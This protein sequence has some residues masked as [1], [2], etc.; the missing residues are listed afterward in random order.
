MSHLRLEN[1]QRRSGFTLV[2]L[3][4]VISIIALL[5]AL[6]L[7]ALRQAR[8]AARKAQ[9]GTQLRSIGQLLGMYA[10]DNKG[11]SPDYSVVR[12]A[13]GG[14]ERLPIVNGNRN[15]T[16][17]ASK[18]AYLGY[19]PTGSWTGSTTPATYDANAMYK[20]LTCPDEPGMSNM[21]FQQFV[22][23]YRTNHNAMG[24]FPFG[25]ASTYYTNSCRFDD[26][27]KP[28]SFF[29]L[30]ESNMSPTTTNANIPQ[31]VNH[32]LD[33]LDVRNH[34]DAYRTTG[35]AANLYG[36][37]AHN[38]SGNELFADFHVKNMTPEAVA[39]PGDVFEDG[40]TGRGTA[41]SD[42]WNIN[43]DAQRR[44]INSSL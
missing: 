25:V 33:W 30:L 17:Y 24:M 11:F 15:T 4:V 43:A 32:R 27:R 20:M 40:S 31:P 9:C 34:I 26:I 5:I 16:G 12:N 36:M 8:S 10:A 39:L 19:L 22:M 38:K 2:E 3:M 29:L 7:P 23:S 1:R 35:N 13:G 21:L 6:L 44:V 18:L 41:T 42:N 37:F 14:W 28:S